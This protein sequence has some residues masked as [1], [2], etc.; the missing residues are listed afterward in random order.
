MEGLFLDI[1]L[2]A[3]F[4]T[5]YMAAWI[6]VMLGCGILSRARVRLARLGREHP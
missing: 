1:H 5:Y 3:V 6:Y 2:T 4:I